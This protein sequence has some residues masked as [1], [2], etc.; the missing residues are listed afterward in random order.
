M[1][2]IISYLDK[3]NM[4]LNKVAAV[5]IIQNNKGQILLLK[6]NYAP[7]GFCLPGGKVNLLQESITNGMIRELY[8]ETGIK[9]EP[10][11]F[12]FRGI[13]TSINGLQ[14]HVF[15]RK[16]AYNESVILSNEHSAY[17]WT[18]SLEDI[19]LA[20]NTKD[21]LSVYQMDSDKH[22]LN[23]VLTFGKYK[24]ATVEMVLDKDAQYLLWLDANTHFKIQNKVLEKAR[25]IVNKIA[26]DRQDA[27][28]QLQQ[29]EWQRQREEQEERQRKL[30]LDTA[31]S[32]P[33]GKAV[34]AGQG[35]YQVIDDQGNANGE[36]VHWYYGWEKGTWADDL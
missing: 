28:D 7:L 33:F 29:E 22:D 36:I 12:I 24:R 18:S 11:D 21:F 1:T 19:N 6:R 27:S 3:I 16:Y 17:M 15:V 32:T 10:N 31:V 25:N 23:S 8:E 14:V 35:N 34:E 26:K 20:G 5:V 9:S 4:D 2:C 13:K 30:N